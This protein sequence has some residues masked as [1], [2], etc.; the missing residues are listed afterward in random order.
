MLFVVQIVMGTIL[1]YKPVVPVVRFL[2][3]ASAKEK[4]INAESR[5][6][7]LLSMV[8]VLSWINPFFRSETDIRKN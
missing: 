2:E 6:I 1:E 8:I 3:E 5:I 4:F 7:V